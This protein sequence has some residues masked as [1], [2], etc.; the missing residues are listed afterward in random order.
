VKRGWLGPL[1]LRALLAIGE[2]PLSSPV[3]E[4]MEPWR[5]RLGGVGEGLCAIEGAEPLTQLRLASKLAS[6]HNPLPKE[7][8]HLTFAFN[9]TS[10][11]ML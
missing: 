9:T 4:D 3:G 8:V 6:L 1:C 7:R 2:R 11:K 10:A 5:L